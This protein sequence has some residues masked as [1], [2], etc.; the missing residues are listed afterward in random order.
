MILLT[1]YLNLVVKFYNLDIKQ[2]SQSPVG[3]KGDLGAAGPQCPQGI[4]RPIGHNKIPET[5]YRATI[6]TTEIEVKGGFWND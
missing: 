3:P 6:N 2:G 5:I 1:K 4:Q